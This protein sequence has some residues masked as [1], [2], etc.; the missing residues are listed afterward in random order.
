MPSKKYYTDL[1][2]EKIYTIENID[3]VKEMASE[4]FPVYQKNRS[5]LELG[6][7]LFGL[8][9]TYKKFTPNPNLK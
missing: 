3:C 4:W 8:L 7:W 1:E 2:K 6:L 5:M 9:F